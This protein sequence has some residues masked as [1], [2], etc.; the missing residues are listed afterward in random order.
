M[1]PGSLGGSRRRPPGPRPRTMTASRLLGDRARLLEC[2]CHGP[3]HPPFCS[4]IE[5][6]ERL[7]V[8]ALHRI[9][10]SPA[11][12]RSPL[13]SAGA[14][15]PQSHHLGQARDQ[16][17][18]IDRP[19]DSVVATRTRLSWP[20]LVGSR[21]AIRGLLEP[22]RQEDS[23]VRVAAAKTLWKIDAR[24]QITLPVLIGALRHK[25]PLIRA[26]AAK[27]AGFHRMRCKAC[28][29]AAHELDR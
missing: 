15:V 1:P 9:R 12:R 20:E 23:R 8:P 28:T 19:R 7:A 14:V 3:R 4:S 5:A 25:H 10:W 11:P 18:G 22:Q 24:N 21:I 16:V 27:R 17:P 2:I 6:H 29:G 26:E 13:G